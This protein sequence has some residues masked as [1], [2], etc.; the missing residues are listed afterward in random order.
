MKILVTGGSG[1]LGSHVADALSADGHEV[2]I[3]DLKKSRYLRSNQ[4]MILGDLLDRDALESAIEGVDIIYHFGALADIDVAKHN[5]VPTMEINIM[6]TVFI[7]EAARKFNIKRVV[8]ASSIYVYSRTG[9]FYKVSKQTCEQLLET[10]KAQHNIDYTILRF[11]T[12]Y[13]TRSDKHNSV[14]R[15]LSE[16]LETKKVDFKGSGDEVREYI[17]VTDA[18]KI[19]AEILNDKYK[20]QAFILTGHHRMTLMEM[21]VMIKEILGGNVDIK[22]NDEINLSHYTQTPY[23]YSPKVGKKIVSNTYCDLGQSLVEILEEID[24]REQEEIKL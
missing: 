20:N 24:S 5:P 12:L 4:K 13:G 21:L 1:F 2:T 9:S 15:Y 19:S 7:M 6:G 8:L 14:Y 22:R 17:H 3:Y 23:S 16:A 10:Y 18:A 11:G